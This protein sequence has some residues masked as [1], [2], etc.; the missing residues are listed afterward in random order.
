MKPI[1]PTNLLVRK[2][3]GS[4][5]PLF[6]LAPNPKPGEP[7]LAVRREATEALATAHCPL[8]EQVP[9][10]DELAFQRPLQ[11]LFEY[12]WDNVDSKVWSPEKG[13]T[14]GQYDPSPILMLSTQSNNPTSTN[15]AQAG[16]VKALAHTNV[17]WDNT[18]PL[19]TDS[20]HGGTPRLLQW[21]QHRLSKVPT[22]YGIQMVTPF[23]FSYLIPK[24][25]DGERQQIERDVT[26]A[27]REGY[28]LHWHL[29]GRRP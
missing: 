9:T 29:V 27:L 18:C 6:V 1:D 23:C 5:T 10:A 3:D 11:V 28:R 12:P 25:L 16:D 22:I 26:L 13:Q 24:L 19:N 4:L 15:P 14:P 21:I 7:L 2:P 17:R 20:N 8:I